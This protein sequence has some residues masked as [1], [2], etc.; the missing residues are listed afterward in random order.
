MPIIVAGRILV[1]PGQRQRFLDASADA[2]R[3]ARTTNGCDDFVVAPDPLDP[4]RVN[5]FELWRTR[6]ALEAFRDAG[7]DDDVTALIERAQVREYE[8]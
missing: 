2:M 4:Q 7:P 8:A 5:I 6:K 3:L 1:Q